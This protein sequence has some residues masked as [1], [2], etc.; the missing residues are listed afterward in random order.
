MALYNREQL[1]VLCA[2]L[3]V[4]LCRAGWQAL[5]PCE[6]VSPPSPRKQYVYEVAGAVSAPGI[7]SYDSQQHLGQLLDAAG[8]RA[9]LTDA[10][11]RSGKVANGSRIVVDGQVTVGC[12]S[13]QARINFFLP[14]I[15]ATATVDDLEL[16]PGMGRITAQ[17]IVDYRDRSGGIRDIGELKSVKGIGPK[18]YERFAPYLT[19]G[20]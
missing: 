16:I 4:A 12:M 9:P 19:A 13:A 18:K 5:A 14:V 6:A 1:M 8:A 20:N 7:Y 2:L 10:A 11:T 3:A 17:A 15:L